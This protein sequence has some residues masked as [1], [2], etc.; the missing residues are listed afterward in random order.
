MSIAS[1]GTAKAEFFA[2]LNQT[3]IKG[4]HLKAVAQAYK[5]DTPLYKDGK[6]VFGYAWNYDTG[7]DA[8]KASVAYCRQLIDDNLEGVNIKIKFLGNRPVN[9]YSS[10]NFSNSNQAL[11]QAVKNYERQVLKDLRSELNQ[12]GKRDLITKLSTI[13]QKTGEY[14]L[15]EDL[16]TDLARA[17]EHL[18]Q[19]ALA[20]HWAELEI[21]LEK[22]LSFADYAISKDP[23]FFSYHDTR[24]LV[25]FRLKRNKEALKAS[26]NA[27]SLKKHPIALD[28]YGDILWESGYKKDAVTQWEQA[29]FHSIDILF[30]RRVELKIKNGKTGDIIFE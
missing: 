25:L 11:D 16:L 22:A 13:L 8:V 19:N 2:D 14:Q 1:P 18:A 7:K 24:A 10:T 6:P 20:Y 5:G 12:T 27:I 9:H 17:G 21:N 30:T 15:S 4:D 29:N 28:H 23:K 3:Y 26:A